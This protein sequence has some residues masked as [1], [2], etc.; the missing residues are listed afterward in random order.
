MQ[1]IPAGKTF[2]SNWDWLQGCN[3]YWW[4]SIV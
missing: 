2:W 3:K 1:K 4:C